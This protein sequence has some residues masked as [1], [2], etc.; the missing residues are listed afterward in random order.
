MTVS[1]NDKLN[2]RIIVKHWVKNILKRCRHKTIKISINITL[3]C[4]SYITVKLGL[5]TVS[6][7]LPVV[8]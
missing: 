4:R 5:V 3:Y 7:S 8:T 6:E 2:L 1:V